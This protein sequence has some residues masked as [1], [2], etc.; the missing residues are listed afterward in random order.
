MDLKL[1]K[2]VATISDLNC[3]IEHLKALFDAGV[4]VVRLNTAHQGFDGALKVIE[5]V[6]KISKHVAIMVDTKGPE[7]RTQN[8]ESPLEVKE[9]DLV[10]IVKK[11]TD[12]KKQ[13]ETNYPHYIE[14]VEVG[15]QILIDDG[16]MAMFVT[17]KK[18]DR[19][20]CRIANS[21]VIKNRKSINTPGGKLHRLEAVSEKDKD[22]IKFSCEQGI[23]FIAHSFVRNKADIVA[24]Q[25]LLDQGGSKAKVIAKIENREGVDN[26]HDILEAAYGIMVARGDLG[27]EIPFEEVPIAQR[28]IIEACQLHAAPV[29]TATQML[30]TM[31]ENPRPTRAEVSDVANAIYQGTDAVMLS[32]ETAYGKYPLEAVQTQTR[33][34]VAVEND[35]PHFTDHPVFQDKKLSRNYLAKAAVEAIKELD[36]KAVIVDTMTGRTARIVSAYRSKVPVF[37]RTSD[38]TVMRSLSLCYGI[39]G[40]LVTK[41]VK[42]VSSFV[43]DS[44]EE[45]KEQGFLKGEDLVVLLVGTP[46]RDLDKGTEILE[47]NTVDNAIAT[48]LLSL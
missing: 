20:V 35:K 28:H 17:E 40:S 5:N 4:N 16:E 13:F 47:I 32:G 43:V 18:S 11:I 10:E 44:L 23:D 45:L 21:G 41:S 9:G 29:I 39:H 7:V 30:H 24:I 48:H 36:I 42:S 27:I 1:T 22:F 15:Q 37:V 2:I 26:I 38:E 25:D 14:E 3:S 6:R 31:I 8:I 46:N 34:A 33:I 19:L 12:P